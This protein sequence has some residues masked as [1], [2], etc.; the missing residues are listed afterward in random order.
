[1]GIGRA[2]MGDG[3][4]DDANTTLCTQCH[5][6]GKSKC[7][8]CLAYC[9]WDSWICV[10]RS[11]DDVEDEDEYENQ[12][13]NTIQAQFYGV[14]CFC[15]CHHRASFFKCAHGPDVDDVEDGKHSCKLICKSSCKSSY[16][17]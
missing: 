7:R 10:S 1:M 16:R 6:Y 2:I 11:D 4:V 15:M 8:L 5:N 13:Q 14:Q 12:P 9:A 3:I 17:A